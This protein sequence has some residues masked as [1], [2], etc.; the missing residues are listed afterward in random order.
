MN[1]VKMSTDMFSKLH[2]KKIE[3]VVLIIDDGIVNKIKSFLDII[4]L[5]LFK[6]FLSI[7]QI[8]R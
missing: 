3:I 7:I 1:V 4:F 8:T 2:K 6:C 5:F